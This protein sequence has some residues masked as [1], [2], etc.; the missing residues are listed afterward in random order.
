MKYN[1][2]NNLPI[3][4][5]FSL[6]SKKELKLY[7]YWFI[8]NKEYRI[9]ELSKAVNSTGKFENWCAD[10]SPSS[11]DNLGIWLEENIKVIKIPDNEYKDIRLKA[12]DYIKVNDWDL[13]IE[14]RSILVDVGIYIGEVFI[15]TYPMLRWEQNLSKRRGD[16]NF[17]HMVI[18]MQIDFNPI[19]LMYILGLKLADHEEDGSCL[20][21]LFKVW[22]C[23]YFKKYTPKDVGD[24]P[25]CELMK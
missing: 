8:E 22:R 2:I 7:E 9:Q 3:D 6:K 4:Y 25:N 11:L 23:Y 19:W 15:H 13:S 20:S 12:P 5:D 14:S 24:I 17:G 21:N 16:N 10:F 18:K 1:I